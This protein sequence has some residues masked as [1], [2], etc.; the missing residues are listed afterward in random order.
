MYNVPRGSPKYING[1]FSFVQAAEDDMQKKNREQMYCPCIDCDNLKTWAHSPIIKSHLIRRG[2][3]EGYMCWPKHGETTDPHKTTDDKINRDRDYIPSSNTVPPKDDDIF[4]SD[5]LKM[6]Q[7]LQDA[8]TEICS[9]GGHRKFEALLE[10]QEKLLY[11]G[12]NEK[13]TLLHFTLDLLRL[14][15]THG[16]SDASFDDLLYLLQ[17]VLTKPNLVPC[18]TYI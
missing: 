17:D 8:E 2:F 9:E 1:V 18:T 14:K 7:M 13:H 11:P 15:A 10:A 3:T 4:V 5:N 6:D 12:C 16:W